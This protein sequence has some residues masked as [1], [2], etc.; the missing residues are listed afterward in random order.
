MQAAAVGKR[1]VD[2]RLTQ[3]DAATGGMQHPLHQIAHLRVGERER[4]ALGDAA[5]GDE[6][7]IGSVHPDLLDRRIVEVGLQRSEAGDGGEHLADAGRFVVDRRS[8]R[9]RARSRCGAAPRRARSAPRARD[10]G[11]DRCARP[12]AA[13]AHARPPRRRAPGWRERGRWDSPEHPRKAARRH[14]EVIHSTDARSQVPRRRSSARV[15]R[16]WTRTPH[17]RIS[18][19]TTTSTAPVSRSA[20]P[21]TS[22]SSSWASC[23]S[24]SPSSPR[25]T[26]PTAPPK[27]CA[28]PS[29][30]GFRPSSI[31]WIGPALVL[32]VRHQAL[33]SRG[34]APSRCSGRSVD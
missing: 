26:S 29:R 12:A 13:R 16:R 33:T 18:R 1:C 17:G 31:N 27:R 21:A 3:V 19:C 24:R 2:E 34:P 22:D 15:V 8:A 6:D 32:P 20:R 7:P 25:G 28:D 5:A 10:R 14:P 9:G 30:R 23:R 4:H 11:P